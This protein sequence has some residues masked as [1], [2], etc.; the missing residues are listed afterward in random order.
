MRVDEK[1]NLDVMEIKSLR[2]IC[3]MD[4][5]RSHEV[6]RRV[7]VRYEMSDRVD[8]KLLKCFG[9]VERLV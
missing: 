2:S 4:R 5:W 8:W 3:G 9:H 7:G 1:H 6:R